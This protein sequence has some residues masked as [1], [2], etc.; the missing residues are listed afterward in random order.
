MAGPGFAV[1]GWRRAIEFLNVDRSSLSPLF[2]SAALFNWVVAIALFFVPQGFLRLFHITPGVDQ[3]FWVREFAGLVF[4]FG[5]GYFWAARDLAANAKIV[6]LAVPAK[7]AVVLVALLSVITGDISWQIL[8]P[9][10]VDGIY[11][12]LFLLALNALS[13]RGQKGAG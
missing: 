7:T 8:I 4:M 5:V 6:R 12:V 3:A 13:T 11:A 2:L 10:S 1:P 9:V